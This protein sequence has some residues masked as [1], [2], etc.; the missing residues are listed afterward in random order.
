MGIIRKIDGHSFA[1][2]GLPPHRNVLQTCKNKPINIFIIWWYNTSKGA[3]KWN[4]L[5]QSIFCLFQPFCCWANISCSSKDHWMLSKQNAWLPFVKHKYVNHLWVCSFFEVGTYLYCKIVNSKANTFID[6]YTAW[7]FCTYESSRISSH[8]IDVVRRTQSYETL[9]RITLVHQQ[10][11]P[12]RG[13][14]PP[15]CVGCRSHFWSLL[16]LSRGKKHPRCHPSNP[17]HCLNDCYQNGKCKVTWSWSYLRTAN[18][19]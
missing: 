19:R 14:P 2:W 17:E 15:P 7:D 12:W 10:T 18:V 3:K 8:Y 1:S 4:S 11:L 9:T 6:E 16:F 13:R 5:F